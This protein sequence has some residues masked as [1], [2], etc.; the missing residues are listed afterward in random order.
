MKSKIFSL[1][2][3]IVLTAV[4]SACS[5]VSTVNPDK[6]K[7]DKAYSFTAN[8]QYGEN[9]AVAVLEREAAYTWR[10]EF[11]EPTELSGVIMTYGNGTVTSYYEGIQADG[12]GGDGIFKK[13]VENFERMIAASAKEERQ[14]VCANGEII[15]TSVINSNPCELRLSKGNN[16]PL[17]LKIA[18]KG[19]YIEFTSAQITS[20]AG[21][22]TAAATAIA[23][24]QTTPTPEN[25][26][27]SKAPGLIV[28]E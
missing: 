8:I 1:V 7:L 17:S 23:P 26:P 24:A 11:T 27:A 2:L 3:V 14:A 22:T 9:E 15:I 18:E 5:G 12:T 16:M 13:I 19:I 20:G 28:H 4:L 6:L 21:L 25:P 10:I